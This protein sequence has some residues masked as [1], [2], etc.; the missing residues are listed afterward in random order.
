M[1]VLFFFVISRFPDALKK[2]LEERISEIFL[3]DHPVLKTY[4]WLSSIRVNANIC[5]SLMDFFY[6]KKKASSHPFS[7]SRLHVPFPAIV[8][9]KLNLNCKK[10]ETDFENTQFFKD[11]WNFAP[12]NFESKN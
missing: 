9:L 8:E 11:R 6:L 1:E 12:P 2:N 5:F 10:R 7:K 4:R 3:C